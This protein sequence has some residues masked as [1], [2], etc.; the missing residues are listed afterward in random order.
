MVRTAIG[1]AVHTVPSALS[2]LGSTIFS[3][4][5]CPDLRGLRVLR[6]GVHLGEIR[7]GVF[8]PDHAWAVSTCPPEVEKVEI[9]EEEAI[10][11]LQGETLQVCGGRKGYVLPVFDGLALGW[12]K[13]T[14]DMM[15]NHYPKGL[16]RLVD[17]S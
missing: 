1:Q 7:K 12:G 6:A 11:Y 4:N 10:R 3:L 2:M 5:G 16:R 15:K 14:G 17:H 8:T 13:V 9:T